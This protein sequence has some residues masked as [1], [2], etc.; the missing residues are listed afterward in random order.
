MAQI[1]A[2]PTHDPDTRV[3]HVKDR[4]TDIR[5]AAAAGDSDVSDLA[6]I[7]LDIDGVSGVR[8]D[9]YLVLI[10]KAPLYEWD[11][12]EGRVLDILKTHSTTRFYIDSA[13]ESM[14]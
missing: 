10:S 7:F 8:I 3:Y 1:L 4:I 13:H 9:P 6:Q 2:Q 11:E 14:P 5:I 12:V